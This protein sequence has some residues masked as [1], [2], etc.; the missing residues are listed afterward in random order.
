ML[1]GNLYGSPGLSRTATVSAMDWFGKAGFPVPNEADARDGHAAKRRL[2]TA[3]PHPD[4]PRA[5]PRPQ[6]S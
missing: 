4:A 1:I 5:T 2:P 6:L 3:P